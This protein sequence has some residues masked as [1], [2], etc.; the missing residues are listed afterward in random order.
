MRNCTS[1]FLICEVLMCL[2]DIVAHITKSGVMREFVVL[3]L[4]FIVYV[5]RG[6]RR[7]VWRF[8]GL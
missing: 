2:L 4:W 6:V 1:F 8:V 3:L 7:E 5:V